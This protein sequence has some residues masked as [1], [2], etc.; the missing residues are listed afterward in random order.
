MA[1]RYQGQMIMIATEP[2]PQLTEKDNKMGFGYLMMD[3]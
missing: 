2:L 3:E 1:G